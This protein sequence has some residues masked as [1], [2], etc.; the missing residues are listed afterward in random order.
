MSDNPPIFVVRSG[1]C[2]RTVQIIF[3]PAFP[4][5][6]GN[7]Q[8]FHAEYTIFGHFSSIVFGHENSKEKYH[9]PLQIGV[10]IGIVFKNHAGREI[11]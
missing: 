2:G 8:A 3:L 9:V 6:Y 5:L 10:K 1:L 4:Y 11:K 7:L